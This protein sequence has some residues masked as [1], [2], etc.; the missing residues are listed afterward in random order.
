MSLIEREER[1]AAE[2]ERQELADIA[3]TE[4][5]GEEVVE[6]QTFRRETEEFGEVPND[7]LSVRANVENVNIP[8]APE[9]HFTTGHNARKLAKVVCET[10]QC[11]VA[12]SKIYDK[13]CAVRF[14]GIG[15][16]AICYKAQSRLPIAASC[17][18]A[19]ALNFGAR[20]VE[21]D[22]LRGKSA[23]DQNRFMAFSSKR[24]LSKPSECARRD[25][26]KLPE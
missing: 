2:N 1:E 21:R 11:G 7:N 23:N 15:G 4:P 24:A 13:Y 20:N 14:A 3:A 8:R 17:K 26:V 9:V 16:P 5:V 18:P 25:F 12:V 19:A 10:A 22:C 6:Q